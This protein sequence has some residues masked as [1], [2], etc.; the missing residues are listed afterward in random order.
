MTKTNDFRTWLGQAGVTD[1]G[2][3]TRSH[4]IRTIERKLE[5]LGMPFRNLSEAWEA[6]GFASLRERLRRMRKDA[7]V[8][9][10][11]YRILMPESEK[12]LKR[13]S[14]WASWLMQY[15]RFLAGDPPGSAKDADRIRQYVFKRYIEPARAEGH[16]Q[17][18]VLVRD[19]N[20]AL[21]LY[22]AWPNICQALAG[23]R[24]QNLAQVPSPERVGAEQSPAT[25]FRF[26]LKDH[27][28]DRSVLRQLRDRFL[29][30]CPDFNTFIDPGTG[31][32]KDERDYKDAA[33]EQTGAVLKDGGDDETVGRAVFEI[34]K[35]QPS[36]SVRF[37]LENLIAAPTPELLGEFH[38]VIGRLVKS[39]QAADEVLSQAFDSLNA[40]R[41]QGVRSLTYGARLN[42]LFLALSSVRPREAAPFKKEFINQAWDKLTGEK[43]FV[44]HT[45][46][47]SSN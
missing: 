17:V 28:V 21:G 10:H 39:D 43:L 8:G 9:G 41:A 26:H 44:E 47:M 23:P 42:V 35:S 4:A 32:A 13:L 1:N 36:I 6:D 31:R 16:G 24:F 2:Q 37:G 22:E 46:D 29:A 38:A 27:R 18:E 33:S 45:A 20:T 19:V 7:K 30:A 34:I 12:P 15:G 3:N 14:S 40:V 5:E 11:D 25:R